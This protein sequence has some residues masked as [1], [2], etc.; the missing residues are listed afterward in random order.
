MSLLAW[1]LLGI[2]AGY[3]ASRLVR[4]SADGLVLDVVLGILG[5]VAG[6]WLFNRFGLAGVTGFS[7]YGL[8]VAIAGA[9]LLLI[10]YH[11]LRRA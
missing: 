11:A 6:G 10:G 1:M 7:V 5:A 4:G 2:I 9:G 3:M 8:F